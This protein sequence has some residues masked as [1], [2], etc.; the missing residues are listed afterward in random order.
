MLVASG[1]LNGSPAGADKG[2][3]TLY[4]PPYLFDAQGRVVG[5]PGC[6]VSRPEVTDAPGTIG[7]GETFAIGSPTAATIAGA[8]LIRPGSVTH[9]FDQDQL[10]VPLD[11]SHF[12]AH[13]AIRVTA[14]RS[15]RD[16]PPGD[17]L[18]FVV[19]HDGVPSIGR[20]VEVGGC[21]APPCDTRPPLAT[22]DLAADLTSE[23]SVTLVWTA[24]GDVGG[25]GTAAYDVRYSTAPISD[26]QAFA[27][28][29][30]F[31]S[32]VPAPG[33]PGSAQSCEITGLTPGTEC[34]FAI[35]TRDL[36]GSWSAVSNP[37]RATTLGAPLDSDPEDRPIGGDGDTLDTA[38]GTNVT[39]T[40][41][42][43]SSGA[44]P[45]V[46]A[47]ELRFETSVAGHVRIEV[48]DVQGRVVRVL[49]DRGFAAGVHGVRW[50]GRG[51][52]GT[53]LPNGVYLAR[54]T[55]GALQAGRRLV[56]TR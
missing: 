51:A 17:Y 25:S 3:A 5:S 6:T 18:L 9:G 52:H 20:W 30:A 32:G 27:W 39:A 54:V 16:L 34:H 22:T 29:A 37:A 45:F 50:D 13:E 40:L 31:S 35:K 15:S 23:S 56:L 21:S 2:K 42:V 19:N 46:T 10:F 24:P 12:A 26:D 55:A 36:P 44:N 7:H 41:R 38:P 14:P 49:A 11:F 53:P 1:N 33:A 47:T 4:T 43:G 8:C 28:A 48:Y